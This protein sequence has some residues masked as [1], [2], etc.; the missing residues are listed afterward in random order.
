MPAVKTIKLASGRSTYVPKYDPRY[1]GLA[2]MQ[3]DADTQCH[4]L[5]SIDAS[6]GSDEVFHADAIYGPDEVSHAELHHVGTC[7]R[8]DGPPGGP[9][10]LAEF[11]TTNFD[12]LL[13]LIRLLPGAGVPLSSDSLSP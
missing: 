6:S 4:P 5:S 12:L 7:M 11:A 1:P 9:L 3:C 10:T 8:G 2:V 13:Q